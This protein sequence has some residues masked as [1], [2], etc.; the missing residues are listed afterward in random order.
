[1]YGEGGGL[2]ETPRQGLG[3]QGGV[4]AILNAQDPGSRADLQAA[5][6]AWVGRRAG[7]RAFPPL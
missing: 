3:A 5:Y 1:M 2:G 7:G 4:G 6:T